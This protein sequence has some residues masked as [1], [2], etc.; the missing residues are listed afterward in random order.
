MASWAVFLVLNMLF[1]L[2]I[3]GHAGNAISIS[4]LL[5]FFP[6][7]A[8]IYSVIANLFFIYKNKLANKQKMKAITE[9]ILWL[10]LLIGFLLIDSG[11]L[12]TF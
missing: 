8:F 6:F 9:I 11:I 10:T 2:E 5:L 12:E 1:N 4:L 3:I 7:F